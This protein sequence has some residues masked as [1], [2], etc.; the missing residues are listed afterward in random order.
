MNNQHHVLPNKNGGWDIKKGNSER[1]SGH[2][3]TKQEAL[4]RARE[5][6]INAKSELIV[7]NKDG[8]IASKDSHG[9]DPRSIP[10]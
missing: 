5:I 9:N 7:H 2:F 10:G 6:S 3:N 4:A 8:S 1:A